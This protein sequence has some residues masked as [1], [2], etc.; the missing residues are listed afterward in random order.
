MV[1]YSLTVIFSQNGLFQKISIPPMEKLTISPLPLYGHPAQI[2]DIFNMI[3]LSLPG[4]RKF[5]LWVGY[6]SF[7]ERPKNISCSNKYMTIII[8]ITNGQTGSFM[9][10]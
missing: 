8:K 6:G 5:P 9:E 2:Q 1:F 10:C 7:L 3:P 4:R